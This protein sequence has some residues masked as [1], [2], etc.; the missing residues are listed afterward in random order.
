MKKL[1]GGAVKPGN[2]QTVG[3]D[4]LRVGNVL[5]FQ[6]LQGSHQG[7][8]FQKIRQEREKRATE[9]EKFHSVG[10]FQCCL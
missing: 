9:C 4:I 6:H 5:T 3:F 10:E 1:G 2:S 8:I 7:R